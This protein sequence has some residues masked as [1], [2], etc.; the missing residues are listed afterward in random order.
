M[1][2]RTSS[3]DRHVAL[4][5]Y[6]S[7]RRLGVELTW[8]GLRVSMPDADPA[9]IACRARPDDGRRHGFFT[10]TDEPVAELERRFP[11]VSAWWGEFTGR[12]WAVT[13]DGTGQYRLVEASTPEELAVLIAELRRPIPHPVPRYSRD[14]LR[15]APPPRPT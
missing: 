6:L 7:A 5:V 3:L 13:R 12:W 4:R 2:K 14:E 1:A 9:G 15:A 8:R 11:G 10:S